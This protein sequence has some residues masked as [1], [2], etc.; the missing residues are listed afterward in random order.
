ML[1]VVTRIRPAATAD[2]AAAAAV[3]RAVYAEYGFTWDEAGYHA[4]LLDVQAAYAAFFVAEREDEIVGTAGLTERGSL[5]RLYVL[6]SARGDGT[7]S[8]LLRAV[9]EEARGRGHR[10]LDIWTDKRLMDAHRLYERFGAWRSG[11]RV[12]DDPDRS[13]EWGY[14]LA[15]EGACA[16]VFDN[17]GRVLVVRERS[18]TSR[19]RYGF[20]GRTLE[21]D[22]TPGEAAVRE[23]REETGA[24][25]EIESRIGSYGSDNGHVVHAF[26]C[27][28]LAGTPE[29]QPGGEL[30]EVGW[31]MPGEIPEPHTNALRYALADALAGRRDIERTGLQ[32]G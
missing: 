6:S 32:R 1:A 19:G 4:D 29:L 31:F 9:A 28:I 24:T 12:N 2:S 22:E 8:A 14:T 15:L 10:R 16:V 30:A 3:V 13:A 27:R 26:R 7:G 11:E 23:A 25:V 5:E 18:G 21:A 20:P 17:E